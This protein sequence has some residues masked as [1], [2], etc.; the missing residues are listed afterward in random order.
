MYLHTKK[1]NSKPLRIIKAYFIKFDNPYDP[2]R[3]KLK[4][5]AEKLDKMYC[6]SAKTPSSQKENHLR[7]ELIS[8]Y[9]ESHNNRNIRTKI[10]QCYLDWCA[11]NPELCIPLIEESLR[12]SHQHRLM[13]H[14]EPSL[15]V[16]GYSQDC[17]TGNLTSP[18]YIN[19]YSKITKKTRVFRFTKLATN[20]PILINS[21]KAQLTDGIC[22]IIANYMGIHAFNTIR[23]A[24]LLDLK[25]YRKTLKYEM[26]TNRNLGLVWK[27][28]EAKRSLEATE[29]LSAAI[30]EN[31]YD[32]LSAINYKYLKKGELGKLLKR[33][34]P[35]LKALH[36]GMDNLK[37]SYKTSKVPI[38]C[39]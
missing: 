36:E 35:C 29:A 13:Y 19:S 6:N 22:L 25:Q 14:N 37:Q 34:K 2:R 4:R 9:V 15:I 11:H 21:Q 28:I 17:K 23:Q 27:N 30:T 1:T 10:E 7:S 39:L 32:N 38:L 24:C 12:K 26:K 31:N 8:L 16:S 5:I 20:S 3:S 33:Y 18:E